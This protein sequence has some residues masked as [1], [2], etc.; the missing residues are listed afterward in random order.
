M[1]TEAQEYILSHYEVSTL[2]IIEFFELQGCINQKTSMNQIMNITATWINIKVLKT[3][4]DTAKKRIGNKMYEENYEVFKSEEA[5]AY[6]TQKTIILTALKI[7]Q[8]ASQIN[9]NYADALV[10]SSKTRT[11][12]ICSESED[13][14]YIQKDSYGSSSSSGRRQYRDQRTARDYLV[15]TNK[16]DSIKL[17]PE[18][19]KWLLSSFN[20]SEEF[21]NKRNSIVQECSGLDKNL[22]LDE[23]LSL[24]CILLLDAD[25]FSNILP[26]NVYEEVCVSMKEHYDKYKEKNND[27]YA[28]EVF[29]FCL[30]LTQEKSDKVEKYIEEST[31]SFFIKTILFSLMNTYVKGYCIKDL[32]ESTLVKDGIVSFLNPFFPNCKEYTTFGADK[33]IKE[34]N[35]RFSKIDPSLSK[36]V[37]K[38]D[39]SVVIRKKKMKSKGDLV[40]ISKYMKDTL[41]AI[42][43]DGYS[44]VSIVDMVFSGDSVST[45]VMEHKHDY[46]Y[47]FYK[48][49]RFYI[50]SDHHDIFRIVPVFSI[51]GQL[52]NIVMES[53]KKLSCQK[54]ASVFKVG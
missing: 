14:D 31:L 37:K 51:L 28:K 38:A 45:Y 9:L 52:K 48:Q 3:S 7:K 17:L 29:G 23:E 34:S 43:R 33:P 5:I 26:T 20:I 21:I 46:V 27:L 54:R 2:D 10:E 8:A 41:D 4:K 11:F 30:L 24:N 16:Q 15:S 39:F 53:A 19:S 50:P 22:K 44:N 32:D 18:D 35:T 6:W 49:G 36:H 12:L 40:K 42:E 13:E 47:T 25:F 1:N